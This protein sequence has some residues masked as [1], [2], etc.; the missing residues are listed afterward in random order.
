M[1]P[2]PTHTDHEGRDP[3]AALETSIP[4]D[5]PSQAMFASLLARDNDHADAVTVNAGSD[6]TE[7]IS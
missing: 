1:T 6:A 4:N 2:Q 7:A 3:H 5:D